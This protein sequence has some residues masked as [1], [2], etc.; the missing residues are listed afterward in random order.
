MARIG[1]LLLN[2][3]K[4]SGKRTDLETSGQRS[5]EVKT[6]SETISD[7]GYGEREAKDYQQMNM[8]RRNVLRICSKLSA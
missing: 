8:G 6:K 7:M 4:A 1:E 5:T 2:I 3:P